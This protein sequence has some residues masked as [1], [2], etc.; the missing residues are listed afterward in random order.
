M[1]VSVLTL[2]RGRAAHLAKLMEGLNRQTRRPD[3]LVIAYMQDYPAACLPDTA[4]PV[5]TVFVPGDPMPLAAA[6]NRAAAAAAGDLLLFLDVDCIPSPDLVARYVQ[7][8]A[9][10]DGI[11]LGEVLYLPAGAADGPLD[12]DL[13]ARKGQRHPAKPAISADEV[14]AEADHGELWG[15]SFALPAAVW[16]QAGGMDERFV[17]YG[18]EETDFAARLAQAGVPMA[19]VGG[20]QAYHQHHAVHIPPLQHF[21]HIL[22]NATLFRQTW[23]RWCM[24][25]WL[26]QFRDRGLIAWDADAITTLRHPTAAEIAATQA[27]GDVLFS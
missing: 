9:A 8:A 26:G 21:D 15:L 6:R 18:A 17:G 23:G 14:R 2:V 22:R 3:E 11:L 13:L 19:W 10:H 12:Y 25:Y 1:T 5:R 27:G 20:A 4:F 16:T 24:D 7:A